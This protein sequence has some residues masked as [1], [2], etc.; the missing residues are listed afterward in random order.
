MSETDERPDGIDHDELDASEEPAADEAPA[1]SEE[2][3]VEEL[4]AQIETLEAERDALADEL[5]DLRAER[6]DLTSRLK[7]AAADFE[8]YKK[9][10]SRLREQQSSEATE[11]VLERLLV[12]RDNLTRALDE[13]VEDLD[14][15]REGV[16]LTLSEFDRVLDAEDVSEI[17]PDPGHRVDPERHEVMAKVESEH[18]EGHI[19]DVYQA[20]YERGEKVLR[21]AQVTVSDGA[22]RAADDADEST[23]DR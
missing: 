17:D 6:D 5:E 19:D 8:N 10:Q 9:R 2:P 1:E 22:G 23:E 15:L 11:R 21:P 16:K 12:V 7:R 3:S 4:S 14:A 20:G 13:D 18:P